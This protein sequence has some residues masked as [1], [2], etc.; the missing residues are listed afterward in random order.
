MFKNR[1]RGIRE[2]EALDEGIRIQVSCSTAEG[3][4]SPRRYDSM[5]ST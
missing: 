5:E 4:L 3:L 1:L 2:K